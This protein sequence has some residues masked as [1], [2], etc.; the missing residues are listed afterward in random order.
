MKRKERGRE[1][2]EDLDFVIGS[3]GRVYEG[4]GWGVSVP[5][6][7]NHPELINTR[8]IIGFLA[9]DFIYPHEAPENIALKKLIEYGIKHGWLAP[10]FAYYQW[11]DV[12]YKMPPNI[13]GWTRQLDFFK[14]PSKLLKDN[15]LK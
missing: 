10:D 5:E 2:G 14:Y 4:R 11:D 9:E 15:P 13:E 3:D 6:P 7:Y 12:P 1:E 8:Y